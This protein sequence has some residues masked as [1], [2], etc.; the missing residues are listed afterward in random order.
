MRYFSFL[1]ILVLIG[2]AQ[3][4]QK[5]TPDT[6]VREDLPAVRQKGMEITK[7]AFGTLSNNLQQAMSEGG[8]S[9]ALKFCNVEAIPLTDSLS[10]QTGTDIRRASHLPRNPLNEADSL[11]MESIR[12]YL[13]KI[14]NNEALEPLTYRSGNAFIYHA[15]IRINN[16]LCLNCHGQPGSD[17]TDDNLA[18]INKLY[19]EDRATGFEMGDLRG[20]WSIRIPKS[21]IDSL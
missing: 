2:C 12:E 13:A 11:E 9:Y 6:A 8:V 1:L 7:E 16:G 5:T 17:I 18:L 10:E 19:S 14:K 3:Q 20:I 21:A 4:Q 15:P